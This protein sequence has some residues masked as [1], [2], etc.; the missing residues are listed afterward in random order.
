M[1]WGDPVFFPE[2]RL[3]SNPA[4]LELPAR[5]VKMSLIVPPL[6]G[7]LFFR[8]PEACLNGDVPLLSPMESGNWTVSI[9]IQPPTAAADCADG[10]APVSA[11]LMTHHSSLKATTFQQYDVVASCECAI[12]ICPSLVEVRKLRC[13]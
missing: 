7:C 12:S 11:F 6:D 1:R 9:I 5:F 4:G 3:E 10:N 13:R 2:G 8:R